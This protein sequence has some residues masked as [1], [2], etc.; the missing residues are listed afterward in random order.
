MA[1]EIG[2]QRR[3]IYGSDAG[4]TLEGDIAPTAG[5]GAEVNAGFAGLD[6]VAET[7][8]GFDK[9]GKCPA[10][11]GFVGRDVD[12]TGRERGEDAAEGEGLR[13]GR[14]GEDAGIGGGE[15][16]LD[17]RVG[18]REGGRLVLQGAEEVATVLAEPVAESVADEAATLFA[19][20]AGCVVGNDVETPR[21]GVGKGGEGVIV[22]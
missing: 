5:T 21:L 1:H 16:E 18:W 3:A 10:G 12:G 8:F 13:S 15:A 20:A 11:G 2:A 14:D 17:E 19:A 22:R 4:A 7:L 9:F 6:G